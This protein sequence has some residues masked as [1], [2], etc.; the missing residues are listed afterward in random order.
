MKYGFLYMDYELPEKFFVK[1]ILQ[2]TSLHSSSMEILE[3]GGLCE[4]PI[5]KNRTIDYLIRNAIIK[6]KKR[7]DGLV[8]K[9]YGIMLAHSVPTIS[10]SE[11]SVVN[12]AINEL[13]F[14]NTL[15]VVISGQPCSIL[16]Y[17]LK[18][19]MDW[20]TGESLNKGV[21]LIGADQVYS[22]EERF[23]FNSAMGDG[24]FVGFV[25]RETEKN[26]ILACV[27]DTKIIATRGELS[28]PHNIELFRQEN[29]LNIRLCIEKALKEAKLEIDDIDCIIPH[30]PYKSLS[31]LISK[32]MKVPREKI[33]DKYI[34]QTG[35]LNSNDAFCHYIS[36]CNEGVIVKGNRVLLI[37][38]GFGGTRGCSILKV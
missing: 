17:A 11:I 30:T 38:P 34:S 19:S 21:I 28:N 2:E 8:E 3:D 6:M 27:T 4:I 1:D 15:K 24:V 33:C 35:H 22:S 36:A 37:N 14:Q 7:V 31:D 5:N 32:L 12:L 9:T 20:L 25:S 23:F 18:L 26:E 10:P 29:P 13:G 16:H